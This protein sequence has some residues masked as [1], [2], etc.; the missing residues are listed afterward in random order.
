MNGK[1][2]KIFTFTKIMISVYTTLVA[3]LNIFSGRINTTWRIS[4]RKRNICVSF[5]LFTNI[6]SSF[7]N[8]FRF[9][10]ILTLPE[11]DFLIS[12]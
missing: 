6:T 9:L 5:S 11:K 2:R 8:I 10:E 3:Y 7:L 4:S 1:P 12:T